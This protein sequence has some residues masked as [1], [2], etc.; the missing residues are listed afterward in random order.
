MQALGQSLNDSNLSA[1][2][3]AQKGRFWPGGDSADSRV[4]MFDNMFVLPKMGFTGFSRAFALVK[5]DGLAWDNVAMNGDN[6]DQRRSEYVAAYLSLAAGQSVL[7]L[8]KNPSSGYA[9]SATW[10]VCAGAWDGVQGDPNPSYT[11][12][13]TNVDA[14]A[15]AHCSLAASGTPSGGLK[16]LQSG[17]YGQVQPGPCGAGCPS[18]CACDTQTSHCVA[19]WLVPTVATDAGSGSD[20][21][22]VE[23]GG[24]RDSG[25]GGDA[26]G[27]GDATLGPPDAGF[28]SQEEGG[29]PATSSSGGSSSG[30]GEGGSQAGGTTPAASSSSGCSCSTAGLAEWRVSPL[31]ALGTVFLALGARRRKRRG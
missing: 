14:I 29:G 21:G 18:E 10:P 3:V 15:T 2:A 1:A 13:E 12:S 31:G 23:A 25:G 9:T 19:P 6:P 7:P 11:C 5:K 24:E 20:A 28:A 17:N 16:A 26:G 27:E 22:S 4:E 30:G 8:M